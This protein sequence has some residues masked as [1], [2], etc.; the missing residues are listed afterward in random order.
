LAQVCL[1]YATQI[2][3]SLVHYWYSFDSWI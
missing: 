2:C 1:T 3:N